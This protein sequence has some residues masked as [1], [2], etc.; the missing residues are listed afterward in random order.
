MEE[1]AM[2]S[3]TSVDKCP[4]PLGETVLLCGRYGFMYVGRAYETIDGVTTYEVPNYRGSVQPMWWCPI[5]Y[6]DGEDG[7]DE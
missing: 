1:M 7:C 2:S 4:P 5:P 3:W 6:F